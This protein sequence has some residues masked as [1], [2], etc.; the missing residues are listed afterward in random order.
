MR[1]YPTAAEERLM[2]LRGRARR[3]RRAGWIDEAERRAVEEA[4]VTPWKSFPFLPRA[5]LFL[6]TFLVGAAATFLADATASTVGPLVAGAALVAI[7]E[8]LIARMGFFRTGIEEGLWCIG[9][10]AII[11][12][13]F[14][15]GESALLL[16]VWLPFVAA[17]ACLALSIRLLHTLLFL[18]GAA[19]LVWWTADFFDSRALAAAAVLLA[20]GTLALAIHLRPAERPFRASAS[21][22]LALG[23]PAIAWAMLR[24]NHL[25]AAYAVASGAAAAWLA[26][27]V[28]WRS[29]FALAGGALAAAAFGYELIEPRV[30]LVE[31][32]ILA[33]GLAAFAIAIAIERF[34]RTPRGGFTSEALD[35][36]AEPRLFEMAAVAA[37]APPGAAARAE[38]LGGDGGKFGGGGATGEY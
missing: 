23:A 13:A 16:A 25:V 22:W 15:L 35:S 2:T 38:G 12:Q 31:W 36:D 20:A 30:W 21:G 7:A 29:R 32:K 8:H 5:G 4:C 27:G 28:R 19:L 9:L 11:L 6:L 26:A 37:V 18:A 3:W 33:G 17:V 34:L 24:E 14:E 1:F 10:I